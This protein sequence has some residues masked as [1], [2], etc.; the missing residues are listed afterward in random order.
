M[1]PELAE[2]VEKQAIR[3]LVWAYSRAV[4]RH[5]FTLLRSLYTEDGIDDHGGIYCGSANGFVD[6]LRV[7]MATVE[8]NHSVH[9]HQ[10]VLTPDGAIGEAYVTAYNRIPNEQGGFDEFI[11][12]LR[13]IDRYRKEGGWWRFVH[14]KVA[15]DYAQHRPAFWDFGHPL[16]RGKCPAV[17]GPDDVSYT[18]LAHPLFAR[19]GGR[20]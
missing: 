1:A 4:D 15:V 6:W 8:T 19:G 18:L 9:N 2:L 14:R 12:G 11:Q 16:L 3:E 13:Y 17:P 5:D 20:S 7:A 10:I